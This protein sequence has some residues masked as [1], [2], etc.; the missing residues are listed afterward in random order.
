MTT[1]IRRTFVSLFASLALVLGMGA[2]VTPAVFAVQN[3][4][5]TATLDNAYFAQRGNGTVEQLYSGGTA[6]RPA[7]MAMW[8]TGNI[9]DS[10]NLQRSSTPDKCAVTLMAQSQGFPI[11]LATNS[12]TSTSYPDVYRDLV[13][14]TPAISQLA[15]GR[16]PQLADGYM[17][18]RA[19][20]PSDPPS[21]LTQ[22]G[23]VKLTAADAGNLTLALDGWGNGTV[24][25]AYTQFARVRL[26]FPDAV[27]NFRMVLRM[28]DA[29]TMNRN[30]TSMANWNG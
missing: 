9:N 29:T 21:T 26:A 25:R 28:D 17:M 15:Y 30:V 4:T 12:T 23:R 13:H 18:T 27:T 8:P 20:T 24:G 16:N 7:S 5:N 14:A 3:S 11:K 10:V 19:A 6:P 22:S 2:V 1:R